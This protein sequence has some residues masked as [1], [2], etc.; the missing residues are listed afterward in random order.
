MIVIRYIDINEV[1]F[2]QP[3]KHECN[4]YHTVDVPF[5]NLQREK[6]QKY[7]E[8]INNLIEGAIKRF[9]NLKKRSEKYNVLCDCKVLDSIIIKLIAAYVT[10][11]I[12]PYCYHK[13][14]ITPHYKHDKFLW[15]IDHKESLA[16]GG[17]NSFENLDIICNRCNVIKGTTSAEGFR[18]MLDSLRQKYKKEDFERELDNMWRGAIAK[19]IERMKKEGKK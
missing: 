4:I 19:K 13:M 7:I 9:N 3:F 14:H 8:D 17:D 5:N 15:T 16:I 6:K 11:F 10:G 18:I 12:C 2:F 1:A